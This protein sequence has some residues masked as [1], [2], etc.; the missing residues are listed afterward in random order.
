VRRGSALLFEEVIQSTLLDERTKVLAEVF[1]RLCDP[2]PATRI[3]IDLHAVPLDPLPHFATTGFPLDADLSEVFDRVAQPVV[4]LVGEH[5]DILWRVGDEDDVDLSVGQQAP[6][7][8]PA[9]I[10]L[11]PD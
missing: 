9:P 7:I 2:S 5:V 3:D 8:R 10:W 4:L 11:R 1:S 6:S